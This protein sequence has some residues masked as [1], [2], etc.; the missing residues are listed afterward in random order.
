[1]EKASIQDLVSRQRTFFASGV[2]RDLDFRLRQLRKL[3][4][5]LK[6]NDLR[7]LDALSSDMKK[8]KLEA[9]ASE[10][11]LVLS[12]I[13]YVAK[14]LR[15]WARPKMALTALPLFPSRCC[16]T[17]EPFGVV[18]ILSP[19]NYPFQLALAPLVGALAAGNCAVIKPSEISSATSSV[20][21]EIFENNFDPRC[22]SVVT[23][24]S[25]TA[26]DL[27]EEKFDY[28]FFTGSSRVGR[29]VME[30]ASRHLTPVTLELGGKSPC[31][32]DSDVHMLYAARRIAWAK[33]FN[34]GQT[35][36]APDYL[37]VDEKILNGF[38]DTL[39]AVVLKFYGTDPS[40]SP[41]FARIINDQH[42][43]RLSSYLD[44][45]EIVVGG[46]TDREQ[47]YIA[48]TVMRNVPPEAPLMQEEVFGPV[49]PVLSYSS[50]PEAIRFVN[51][52]PK[53][54]S[55]YLFSR[56]RE[57]HTQVLRETSSG[58]LCINDA[59]VHFVSHFLPFG[60]V[61]ESGMGTY[62]GRASFETFSHTKGVV[63][64]TLA[65]DI[66]LRYVPY[67]FKLQLVKWFF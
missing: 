39:K 34:A 43:S 46:Q 62:H 23:G 14:R 27:L 26:Q 28:I 35:C 52:R 67:R 31:I 60:G 36:V 49:L 32:V 50:F 42:F 22:V 44:Q 51:S 41:D 64:N 59:V 38:L 54:L 30:A 16:I 65:F 58:A 8:P 20:L 18:L 47:R 53:P 3:H 25:D 56:D 29:R 4:D 48:P 63:K 66:P 24:G 33:F 6:D 9:Y 10:I 37:L 13:T 12:E 5:V 2:T 55:L 15:S 61:G 57:H 7:I 45:G 19:W 11:S 1:M 40:K 17:K 21:A